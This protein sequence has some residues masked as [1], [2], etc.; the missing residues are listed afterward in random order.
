MLESCPKNARLNIKDARLKVR[1]NNL[2]P[3]RTAQPISMRL[4]GLFLKLG[5]WPA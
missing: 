1:D 5:G 3:L 2:Y 4:N